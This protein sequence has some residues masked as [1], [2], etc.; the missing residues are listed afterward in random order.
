[1]STNWLQQFDD[2]TLLLACVSFSWLH[3]INEHDAAFET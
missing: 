2:E 3:R 1:M